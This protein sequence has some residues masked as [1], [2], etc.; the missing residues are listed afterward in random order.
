MYQPNL[1]IGLIF[2]CP[3]ETCEEN[4]PFRHTRKLK[5]CTKLKWWKNLNQEEKINLIK[6]HIKCTNKK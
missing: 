4:C 3:K 6:H 5:N 1:Y 2:G